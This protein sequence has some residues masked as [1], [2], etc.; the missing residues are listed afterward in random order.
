[1]QEAKE[2]AREDAIRRARVWVDPEVAIEEANLLTGNDPY[3]GLYDEVTCDYVDTK[4]GGSVPKFLCSLSDGEVIKVNTE[5][6][7]FMSRA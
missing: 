6:G 5:T 4:L 1:M 3:F 2:R 7:E